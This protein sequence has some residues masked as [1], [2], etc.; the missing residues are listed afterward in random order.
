MVLK[1]NGFLGFDIDGWQPAGRGERK[2]AVVG[3]NKPPAAQLEG[4]GDVKHVERA[5][6]KLS[7]VLADELFGPCESSDEIEGRIYQTLDAAIL[8]EVLLEE[9]Q[10]VGEEHTAADELADRRL[11]LKGLQG[12]DRQRR[13]AGGFLTGPRG[14]VFGNEEF[15]QGAG[16]EIRRHPREVSAARDD[17]IGSGAALE[18]L[19]AGE[20]GRAGGE[21]GPRR[22]LPGILRGCATGDGSAARDLEYLAAFAAR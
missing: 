2:L 13:S 4:R 12:G 5:A 10:S 9:R 7:G 17:E 16:V 14:V 20:Q 3:G 1:G 18:R 21:I 15:H 11:Q 19:A 8:R 6:E 22:G